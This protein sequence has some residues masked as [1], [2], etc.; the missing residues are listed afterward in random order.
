[1][2]EIIPIFEDS[3]QRSTGALR[4]GQEAR[5][6]MML[7]NFAFSIDTTAYHQLTREASWRWSEQERIG[8]QDLLQYTGKPG[9]T[10]RLEGQSHAFFRKGVGAVNELFDLAEQAKPQQLVSGE[11]DVLG[12]WVVTDFSDTTSKF[13]PGGGHRNK[14]WTMTLKHYADDLSNP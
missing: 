7:G 14:N 1:M 6:M 12:W 8:K 9:R 13:L 2:S 3:G 4:G 10:V 5:V 11:G